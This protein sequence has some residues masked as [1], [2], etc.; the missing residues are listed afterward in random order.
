MSSSQTPSEILKDLAA[1]NEPKDFLAL[2]QKDVFPF[3][4]RLSA[5][6]KPKLIALLT[7]TAEENSGV[8]DI[9]YAST[10]KSLKGGVAALR[11][12]VKSDWKNGYDEQV[13]FK[14]AALRRAIL[15]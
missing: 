10:E 7:K 4:D 6:E 5:K 8:A 15:D 14:D 13:R 1:K 12:H 3:L 11:K 9:S 2:L